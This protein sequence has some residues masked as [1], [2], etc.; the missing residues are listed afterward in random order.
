M[1]M[2]VSRVDSGV[3]LLATN[4]ITKHMQLCIPYAP[5]NNC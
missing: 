3:R 4:A 1:Q 5:K 2:T